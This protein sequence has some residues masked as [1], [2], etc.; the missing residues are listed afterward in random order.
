MSTRERREEG[1]NG[2]TLA[3]V[4]ASS[5]A[6][7]CLGAFLLTNSIKAKQQQ[8]QQQ[9]QQLSTHTQVQ[10]TT[11]R[12][13]GRHKHHNNDARHGVRHE[14]R[15]KR[16][17]RFFANDIP[18]GIS[19]GGISERLS[20]QAIPSGISLGEIPN[21]RLGA[22]VRRTK[23]LGISAGGTTAA[24][25]ARGQ[26]RRSSMKE[27]GL[28]EGWS[29]SRLHAEER[30]A[31]FSAHNSMSSAR[32][33]KYWR[34]RAA[35]F[36]DLIENAEARAS[37]ADDGMHFTNVSAN[38]DGGVWEQ[39]RQSSTRGDEGG[40]CSIYELAEPDYPHQGTAGNEIVEIPSDGDCLFH[41]FVTAFREDRIA[42]VASRL[43]A[44]GTKLTVEDLRE[45]VAQS[46][47]SEQFEMLKV[48]YEDAQREKDWDQLQDYMFMRGVNT[49]EDLRAVIRTKRYWGDEIA[50][51]ALEEHLGVTPVVIKEDDQGGFDVAQ[52][53]KAKQQ[54]RLPTQSQR[55]LS[56]IDAKQRGMLFIILHL[57]HS[58]YRLVRFNHKTILSLEDLPAPLRERVLCT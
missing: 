39:Q 49:L 19:A 23:R 55:D 18:K 25:Q 56:E 37:P 41:C 45:K 30:R 52:R 31:E 40:D 58:H 13:K 35:H 7:V 43:T 50:L 24:Q 21:A 51:S 34:D 26:T 20:R 1:S 2:K 8:H 5:V 9:Q 57:Q 3:V 32:Q 38:T 47:T 27:R 10:S 53:I 48:I 14:V 42:P 44:K 15:E 11:E 16:R 22:R 54:D 4:V 12:Q 28:G 33:R 46:V 17:S 6:A 36:R 29:L